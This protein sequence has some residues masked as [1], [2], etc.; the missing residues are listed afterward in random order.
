MNSAERL[1]EVLNAMFEG[2]NE[3]VNNTLLALGYPFVE[4]CTCGCQLE[5]QR[6]DSFALSPARIGYPYDVWL[7]VC[8]QHQAEKHIPPRIHLVSSEPVEAAHNTTNL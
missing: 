3:H 4:P 6:N 7:S 1:P 2:M 8:P 5:Y